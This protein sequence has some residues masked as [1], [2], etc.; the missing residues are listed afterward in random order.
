MC[1]RSACDYAFFDIEEHLRVLAF[2]GAPLR[3]R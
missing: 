2:F 3:L 1:A